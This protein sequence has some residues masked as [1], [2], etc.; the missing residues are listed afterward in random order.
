MVLIFP[1]FTQPFIVATDASGSGV[2]LVLS[3][4][5]EGYERPIAYASRSFKKA[6]LN[7]STTE[8]ELLGA[9]EMVINFESSGSRLTRWALTLSEYD[10]SVIHRKGRLHGNADALSR[11]YNKDDHFI[12]VEYEDYEEYRKNHQVLKMKKMTIKQR[13]LCSVSEEWA[14]GSRYGKR[15]RT[16]VCKYIWI[17]GNPAATT[18]KCWRGQDKDIFCQEVIK[19]V[20]E[21]DAQEAIHY[22]SKDGILY[23]VEN[24]DDKLIVPKTFIPKVMEDFHDSLMAGHPGQQKTLMSLKRSTSTLHSHHGT[25]GVDID[26]CCGTASNI[27]QWKSTF[28]YVPRLF[29]KILEAIP[30]PDQKADTIARAFVENVIVRYGSPKRLLTDRGANSTSTLFKEVCKVLGI[31]KLQTA[32][33]ALTTN[34]QIERMHRVLKDMLSHYISQN[35]RDWDN[36]I[37]FVLMAYRGSTHSSTGYSPYFL[38]HGYDYDDNYAS[39]LLERLGR[40]YSDVYKNTE[41]AKTE[42]VKRYN[43]KTEEH[44]FNFGD[45]MKGGKYFAKKENIMEHSQGEN[46]DHQLAKKIL[47]L[48]VENLKN[49]HQL[50]KNLTDQNVVHLCHLKSYFRKRLK[51]GKPTN[52]QGSRLENRQR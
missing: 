9:T 10:L 25:M 1:D 17:S 32:S 2:G 51:K 38:P 43:K 37:P 49:Q 42:R 34:G 19:L 45:Q 40:V 20:K 27:T 18:E 39:E 33:Y 8:K 6:E 4:I 50:P 28:A 5:R 24:D 23:R 14:L 29:H 13:N 47:Q 12:D 3:Q 48:Q 15:N 46:I 30:L 16:A 11:M 52:K 31:G 36:W 26:E 35:Q 21:E 44:K 7:Y 41:K 22:L